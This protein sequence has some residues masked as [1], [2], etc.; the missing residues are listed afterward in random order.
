MFCP[1]CGDETETIKK[2]F[3]AS[4][5]IVWLAVGDI[6][7]TMHKCLSCTQTWEVWTQMNRLIITQPNEFQNF[8]A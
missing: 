5:S 8:N 4:Y 3:K 7:T 6:E 2:H 1:K